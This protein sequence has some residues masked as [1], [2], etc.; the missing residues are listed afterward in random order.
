MALR[1]RLAAGLRDRRVTSAVRRVLDDFLP[2]VVREW[3]PLNRF[4]A[5]RFHGA[6][7]DL[8]FK[9]R[10]F[11]MSPRQIALA[12]AAL[13]AG[14]ARYRDSDTTPAQLDAIAAAARGRVL[15]VGCGNGAVAERLRHRH[16]VIAV[17]VTLASATETRRRARCAVAVAGLPALPFADRAFDTVVCAH[18]L[19]HIPDLY[20]AAAELRRVAARAIIVVPRQRYYR[21]T[22]DYHLHFFP[23]AAPLIYLFGGRAER[24]DGD[25]LVVTG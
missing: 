24:I 16:H 25:W 1:D 7:F 19:E 5:T 21:Y 18:T 11:A 17:D 3:R 4:L 23:S 14:R 10:A 13:D 2:P 12:Y 8:D 22:V 9:E 15:E 20:G 6:A